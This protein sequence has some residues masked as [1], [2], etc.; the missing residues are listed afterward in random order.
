MRISIVLSVSLVLLL[1][2][3]SWGKFWQAPTFSDFAPAVSTNYT[4]RSGFLVGNVTNGDGAEGIEIAYDSTDDFKAGTGFPAFKVP[5]PTGSSTWRLDSRHKIFLRLRY[6]NN[7]YSD[8][9]AYTVR[10]GNN[11]DINGDGY[12]D[13]VVGA[14][15]YNN[16]N[17]GRAYIFLSR[18]KTGIA[19][20]NAAAANA[21]ITGENTNHQFG[22]SLTLDDLNGDGYADLVAGAYQYNAGQ[23][24]VYA[25]HS[26]GISG[27]A[28]QSAASAN[29]KIDGRVGVNCNL[30]FSV[31]A[32]DING[33]GYADIV[34]G[35]YT[36]DYVGLAANSGHTYIFHSSG[37][38][39]ITITSAPAATTDI[40]GE[41]NGSKFGTSVAVGDFNADGFADLVVGAPFYTSNTGRVF[42]FNGAANGITS[43]TAS[44]AQSIAGTAT[45]ISIGNSVATGDFNGDGYADIATGAHGTAPTNTGAAFLFLSKPNFTTG[46]SITTTSANF[47][48]SGQ[49][50]SDAFGFSVAFGDMN[51]DGKHDLFAHA[52]QVSGTSRGYVF[53]SQNG[54]IAGSN[55]GIANTI[56]SGEGTPDFLG[57]F[58]GSYDINADGYDDLLLGAHQYSTGGNT[59][60][61][62]IFLS[63]GNGGVIGGA[64]TNANAII[65][66][67]AANNRF[68]RSMPY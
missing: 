46:G 29:T 33:D 26:N 42:L 51:G 19:T 12:P 58:S 27:I 1:E 44:P 4:V 66:G 59:G 60:R 55:A 37:N 57:A 13:L 67:E 40:S 38:S 9:A 50:T 61:V 52:Q 15:Q 23:G 36:D 11:R 3:R 5:L 20:Q 31:A 18:G 48:I 21:I 32:G 49:A 63:P 65:T 25:F 6:P 43:Q 34:A 10:K 35:A 8:T 45:L 41:N 28:T 24:R 16:N 14:D 47:A 22:V 62:Y 30:G 39:G 7:G 56:I 2:C 17:T 68:G 53:H 64:A 54:G